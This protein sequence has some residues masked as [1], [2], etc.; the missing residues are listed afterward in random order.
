MIDV[1]S[2][3]RTREEFIES[4]RKSHGP[5]AVVAEWLRAKSYQVT[6]LPNEERGD[7]KD[8]MKFVDSG[9]LLLG[10]RVEVKQD[11]KHAFSGPDDYPFP[12]VIVMSKHAWDSKKPMPGFVARVDKDMKCAVITNRDTREH[13]TVSDITDSRDGQTQ[14]VYMCPIKYCKF[15]NL[16]EAK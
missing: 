16:N 14:Q 7:Y 12:T 1:E 11:C 9:D 2:R 4:L 15:V 6:L 3:I 5:V 8:R 10:V 13:W